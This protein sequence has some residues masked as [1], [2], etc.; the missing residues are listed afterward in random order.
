MVVERGGSMKWIVMALTPLEEGEAVTFGH[1]L[2]CWVDWVDLKDM[3]LNEI[4]QRQKDETG[5]ISL[6]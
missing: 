3:M 6:T 5:M 1:R 4:S 2:Q